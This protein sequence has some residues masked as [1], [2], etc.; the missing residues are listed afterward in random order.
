MPKM[1]GLGKG[2]DALFGPTPEEEKVKDDDI[3]KNL[4]ITE[5]EPNREQPRK[6]FNQEALE[7]LAESIK[8]YGLIQPIVVTEKDG[9]YCIIAGERR[10][11]A[12]KLAGLEEIPAIVREDD[13]RKNKEIA[14]I[15]NIQ[16]EDL[17]P[18]EKALG[19]KNL[20]ESYNL[21]Q[22]EVAKKLGK[23]RSTIANSIRVLNLEPRVL[24]LAKQG[25]ISEAHC[26]LLLSITDP[27]KQYL[28]AIDIIERGTTTRELEQTNKKIN[29]KQV[30]KE[31]LKKINILYKDIENTF[32]GFFGTKVKMAPGKKRGK[33]I[34]EYASNDDLERILNIIK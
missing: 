3:L 32:Q 29:Q 13:E 8:E 10:W 11:R 33:I 28:T 20:M 16:R 24:E 18:F 7:E 5:V 15:E 9:Y 2:L 30:S 27:E 4:K 6:N 34:I 31:E 12:C 23:G 14:L 26:K 17:N 21:T 1:T 25:K 19:I 22:E